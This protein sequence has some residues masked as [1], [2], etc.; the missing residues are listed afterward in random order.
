MWNFFGFYLEFAHFPKSPSLCFLSIWEIF[1]IFLWVLFQPYPLIFLSWILRTWKVDPLLESHTCLRLCS[2][3]FFQ[4]VDQNVYF[5]SLY[6]HVHWCFPLYSILLLNA[7]TDVFILSI[8]FFS[9]TISI[10]F[11]FMSLISFL[12]LSSCFHLFQTCSSLLI[13]AYLSWPI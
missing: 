9:G 7:I 4:S 10:W 13:E 8:E 1:T 11:S 2:I 3:F 6:L 5:L 12:R